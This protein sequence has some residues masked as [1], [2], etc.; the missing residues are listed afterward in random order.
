MLSVLVVVAI[1]R[2]FLAA[3]AL[4]RDKNVKSMGTAKAMDKNFIC[5]I[6]GSPL[7]YV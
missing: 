2:P 6:V 5:F 3:P 4:E 7:I 1:I